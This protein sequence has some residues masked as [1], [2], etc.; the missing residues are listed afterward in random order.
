M[1]KILS[2]IKSG[3]FAKEWL[4]ENRVG[5]PVFNQ[6]RKECSEQEVEK[7]GGRLRKMMSWLIKK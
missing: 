2:E 5:R 4:L 1:K 6:A 3:E 7:V